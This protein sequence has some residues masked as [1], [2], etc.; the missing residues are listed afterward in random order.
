MLVQGIIAQA[1]GSNPAGDAN[2]T[3]VQSV[4]DSR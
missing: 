3:P 2:K 4:K 1:V